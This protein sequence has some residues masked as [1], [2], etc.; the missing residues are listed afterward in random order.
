MDD[1]AHDSH[2]LRQLS[3]K[4]KAD[5]DDPASQDCQ[6]PEP[7]A[8]DPIDSLPPIPRHHQWSGS[9]DDHLSPPF[10]EEA[11]QPAA[12]TY[13]TREPKRPKIQVVTTLA[14]GSSPQQG[15]KGTSSSPQRKGGRPV[16]SPHGY[17]ESI[18]RS[19]SPTGKSRR[20]Q[21]TSVDLDSP[22]IPPSLP[23]PNRETLKELELDAVLCNPQLRE[24][25]P[26]LNK[27]KRNIHRY[28]QPSFRFRNETHPRLPPVRP[29]S[30]IRL[31]APVPPH[32]KSPEA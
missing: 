26:S 1:V 4:R 21:K 32:I 7:M 8:V 24:S 5:G 11:N 28:P 9:S 16:N 10:L 13:R 2:S 17:L 20:H 30:T 29:R 23:I 22:H 6:P 27:G 3:R 12:P 15:R 25:F 14:T 31:R 18:A 19:D